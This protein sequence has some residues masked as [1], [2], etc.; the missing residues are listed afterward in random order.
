MSFINNLIGDRGESEVQTALLTP[1]R[2]AGYPEQPFLPLFLGAKAPLFD[3]VVYLLDARGQRL[4]SHFF[5]QVKSTSTAA[6]NQSCAVKM[7]KASAIT[8]TKFRCP[9]YLIGADVSKKTSCDLYVMGISH[10]QSTTI[11]SVPVIHSLKDD[12]TKV[13]IYDEVCANFAASAY[14]FA[15]TV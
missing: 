6:T 9:S 13:L 15:S 4:G 10:T 14:T 12:T 3:F 8:A 1:V 5:V 7:G 2:R 11:L